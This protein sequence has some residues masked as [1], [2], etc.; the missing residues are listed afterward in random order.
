[1]KIQKVFIGSAMN[2]EYA[3]RARPFFETLN[4]IS[5]KKQEIDQ[6]VFFIGIDFDP[7]NLL[8]AHNLEKKIKSYTLK[9][10]ELTDPSNLI[11]QHGDFLKCK[12]L[13]PKK[14]D[15]ILWCDCDAYFQRNLIKKDLKLFKVDSICL[16]ILPN[17]K[18]AALSKEFYRIG[19]NQSPLQVCRQLDFHESLLSL[20]TFNTGMIGASVEKWGHLANLYNEKALLIKEFFPH[21]ARQQFLLSLIIYKNFRSKIMPKYTHCDGHYQIPQNVYKHDSQWYY[22]SIFSKIPAFYCHGGVIF[23]QFADFRQKHLSFL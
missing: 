11:I 12:E 10:N 3:E 4:Y 6:E 21:Y 1:M 13:K 14:N 7:K 22:R 5:G 20:P 18:D 19:G 23:E 15:Y 9:K 16:G 17:G 2:E 8:K